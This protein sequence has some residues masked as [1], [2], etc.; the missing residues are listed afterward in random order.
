M[1]GFKNFIEKVGYPRLIIGGFLLVLCISAAM[2][3]IPIPGLISDILI[4]IGMN[5]I[6]VLAM[7]PAIQAGVGLNFALPLGVVCGLIGALISIEYK[8]AGFT[9]LFVAF[10]VAIPIAAIVGYFYGQML[11]KMKGQ[12]MT[13]GTY[14]GFSVVSGMC[15]FWLLAPFKSPELIWAVGGSGLR[16]TVSL[17][18]SIDKVLNRFLSFR[19]AGIQVPTGLLL[20]FALCC[21][22]VWLFNKSKNGVI[23]NAAGSNERFASATGINVNRQRILGVILSTILGA[24][25]IIVFS[26]SFGFLQL[27]NA[28]LFSAMP[29]VAAVLI[30]GASIRKVK[31][32]HVVIGTFLFQALLVV[33][34]PVL[35]TLA[36]GSMS[37]VI[38]AI[39]QNGIILYALTRKTGGDLA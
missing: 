11:N 32:S 28:P 20:F 1:D 3:S 38:R 29:A 31:I 4:R 15:I 27:Y 9:G 34:L 2:L 26:Q 7:V 18:S 17:E 14:V 35:N 5:G 39:V 16:V 25:G 19:F 36:D 13:V 12:E 24:V 22:I 37:E 8:L 10:A 23:M 33:A 6:L 21:L 30:G